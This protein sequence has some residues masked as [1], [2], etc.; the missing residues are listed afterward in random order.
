MK[1]I[2]LISEYIKGVL[3]KL[4]TSFYDWVVI[5]KN[6]FDN[7]LYFEKQIDIKFQILRWICY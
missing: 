7:K 6:K 2:N 1:N 3:I 4:V 5:F